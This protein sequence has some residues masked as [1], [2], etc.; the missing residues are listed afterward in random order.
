VV[1]AEETWRVVRLHHVA[2]AHEG[3]GDP[4]GL[5]CSLLG[6]TM[7][8]EESAVGLVERMLPA[9]D[10]YLQLLEA[11]GPGVVERFVQRR[12]P[13]LHHVAFEV[14]DLDDAVSDLRGRGVRLIDEVAR[15]GGMGTRIAFIHPSVVPGLL[16]E[17]VSSPRDKLSGVNDPVAGRV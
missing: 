17:L 10:C 13:G 3:G 1:A 15:P 2:F 16:I 8:H 14:S 7:V 9:G 4:A 12:G 5:L 11:T 6:L